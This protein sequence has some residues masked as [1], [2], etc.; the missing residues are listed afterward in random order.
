MLIVN[1]TGALYSASIIS[2]RFAASRQ[3][4]RVTTFNY[5]G[6]RVDDCSPD[7]LSRDEIARD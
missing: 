7:E 1:W 2:L 6:G 4:K 3:S 5:D